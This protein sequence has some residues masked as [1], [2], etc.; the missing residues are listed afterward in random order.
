MR[1]IEPNN[2]N[3]CSGGS[4][5][6][7]TLKT[8]VLTRKTYVQTCN[9]YI[10]T[11]HTYIQIHMCMFINTHVCIQICAY[12]HTYTCS[13]IHTCINATNCK[14]LKVEVVVVKR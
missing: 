14:N 2:T 3:I 6:K 8:N 9:A 11:T 4:T 1:E 5:C 10:N 7:R 12:M 13:C